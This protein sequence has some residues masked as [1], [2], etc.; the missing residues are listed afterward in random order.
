MLSHRG[1]VFLP[2]VILQARPAKVKPDS[3]A[4]K[5]ALR[6][7]QVAALHHPLC[8]KKL[9]CPIFCNSI[10]I[11]ANNGDHSFREP[12]ELHIA[13]MN[14]GSGNFPALDFSG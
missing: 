2:L 12:L 4:E 6:P 7:H 14:S 9:L 1:A 3:R 5:P 10:L 13:K 11:S 8:A